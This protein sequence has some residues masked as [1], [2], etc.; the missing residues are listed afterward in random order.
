MK[1]RFIPSQIMDILNS[2]KK[3]AMAC[4]VLSENGELSLEV[5]Y[6]FFM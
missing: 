2:L 3:C 4:S 5:T 1:R 6:I